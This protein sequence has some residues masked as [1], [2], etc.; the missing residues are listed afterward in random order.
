MAWSSSPTTHSSTCGPVSSR[1]SRSCVGLTSWYSST[2]RCLRAAH[3][4]RHVRLLQLGH[5]PGDQLPVGSSRHVRAFPGHDS[6]HKYAGHARYRA[7]DA[8]DGRNAH[9]VISRPNK[10]APT[11][12]S[13]PVTAFGDHEQR[14]ADQ[15]ALSGRQGELLMRMG[16]VTNIPAG[17]REMQQIV[18]AWERMAG[19]YRLA[20]FTV[21]RSVACANTECQSRSGSDRRPFFRSARLLPVA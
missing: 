4:A 20:G 5:G 8:H 3:F 13:A 19:R 1:I 6:L 14:R 17:L 21:Y 15:V 16:C 7:V 18:H 2:I 9:D 12:R 10:R 11:R